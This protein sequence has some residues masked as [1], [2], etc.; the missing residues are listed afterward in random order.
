MKRALPLLAL[1]ALAA[2]NRQEQSVANRF[3]RTNAEIENKARE[4]EA[5]VENEVRGVEADMQN[6]IDAM[7]NQANAAAPAEPGAAVGNRTR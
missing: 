2:C 1:L 3:D 6:Q 5:E 7:A 4:L